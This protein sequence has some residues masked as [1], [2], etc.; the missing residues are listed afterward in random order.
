MRAHC[1]RNWAGV[2]LL[3]I[4]PSAKRATRRKPRSTAVSEALAP[5]FQVR[6][7]GLLAIQIGHGCWTGRGSI[8]TP[9]NW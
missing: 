9:S 4:Q 2:T 3:V 6:P 5:P 7:V 1:S 8:F